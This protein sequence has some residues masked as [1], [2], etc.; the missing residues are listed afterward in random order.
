MML[1]CL[2]VIMFACSIAIGIK[3]LFPSMKQSIL[4]ALS[5]FPVGS[6]AQATG[7]D[8]GKNE[9]S[10]SICAKEQRLVRAF[11]QNDPD[12]VAALYADD[13]LLI[14]Y[15]GTIVNKAGVVNALRTGV[16]RFDSLQVSELQVRRYGTAAI[17]TGR[18]RQV[19]REP[20]PDVRPHP[21]DVRYTNV[22]VLRH[23]IWQLVSTQ[24]TA[25]P[26]DVNQ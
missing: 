2:A 12:S 9:A 26:A 22:Y 21:K 3:R 1:A 14:N 17:L 15:R 7:T 25:L 20:G 24:I 10:R 18:Q 13:F 5:L 6:I 23:G 19:A 16:L 4:I 11:R 8:C